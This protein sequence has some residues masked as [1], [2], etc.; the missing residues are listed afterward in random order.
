MAIPTGSG[1]EVLKTGSIHALNNNVTE[2]KLDGSYETAISNTTASA[3]PTNT[4]IT[5]LTVVV[6]NAHDS[7]NANLNLWLYN[8][9]NDIFLTNAHALPANTTFVWSDTLV[10]QPTW[11]IKASFDADANCDVSYTYIIQDWT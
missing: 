11:K 6:A 5:I 4:I 10:L 3:V 8:G 7:I 9:T 2:F 1:S